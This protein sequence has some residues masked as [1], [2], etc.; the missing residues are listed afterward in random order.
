LETQLRSYKLKLFDMREA[1]ERSNSSA[2]GAAEIAELKTRLRQ[3]IEQR[4]TAVAEKR[5]L[6]QISAQLLEMVDKK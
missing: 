5:E 3:A 4:D 6:E 2:S 1:L